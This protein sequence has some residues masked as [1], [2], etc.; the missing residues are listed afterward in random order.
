MEKYRVHKVPHCLGYDYLV[1]ST[2][3]YSPYDW[4]EELQRK[5]NIA[6]GSVVIFDQLLQIG[7]ADKRFPV[8]TVKNKKLNFKNL[9]YSILPKY[10]KRL[11]HYISNFLRE[12]RE[13][14][15]HS[16]LLEHEKEQILNGVNI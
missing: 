14:L 9:R 13:I 6:D 1:Y 4:W 16:I 8:F 7:N 2:S 15:K 3:V 5:H 11:K 12:N 10:T